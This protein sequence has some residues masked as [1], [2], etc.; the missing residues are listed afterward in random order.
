MKKT[1]RTITVALCFVMILSLATPLAQATGIKV[2]SHRGNTSD[3]P[4]ENTMAAF[5]AASGE[6][7]RYIESD[8]RFTKDGVAVLCHDSTINRTARTKD[9]RRIPTIKLISQ[10]SY[11]ELTQY[12]F[13]IA[14]GEEY[15][16]EVI[17]TFEKWLLFCRRNNV[18]PYI[19]LKENMTKREIRKL[20][21]IVAEKNMQ[22]EVVWI[23]FSYYAGNLFELAKLEPRAEIGV[24]AYGVDLTSMSLA[25]RLKRAQ[26]RVFLDVNYNTLSQLSID[27]AKEDGLAVEAWTVDS[28]T[29][30]ARLSNF[31]VTGITTNSI[32][33]SKS[34]TEAA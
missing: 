17:P 1:S 2:I 27:R 24:L 22:N 12:D 18:V 33:P 5:E 8:V 25:K 15:A 9:G 31:G 7:F 13:G 28:E 19:E 26:N 16:G 30:F 29:A 21:D 20:I 11:E 14:A 4:P 10:M 34:D 32:Q 23:C 3:N 6:G